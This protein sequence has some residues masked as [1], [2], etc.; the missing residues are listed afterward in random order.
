MTKS[1]IP[2]A[3][4]S[5][6][7]L[8]AAATVDEVYAALRDGAADGALAGGGALRVEAVAAGVRLVGLRTPTLPP[9]THTSCYWLG[10]DA[11]AG[12]FVAVDP[13]TPYADE[14]GRLFELIEREAASGRV[15]ERVIL[16]HHH[17]DHVGAADALR[18]RFGVPIAA[19]PATAALLAGVL[20]IDEPLADEQ[21]LALGAASWQVLATPGHAPGHVCLWRASDGA[22]VAGDMVAGIGTILIDPSDG[23]M[24]AYLGSL[25][26]LAALAPRA[27][28]PA[29][30]PLVPDGEARLRGYV[31]HR[32]AREAR[33]VAA[34][35]QRG[36]ASVAR[37]TEVAYADTPSALWP[38][39]ARSLSSH[40]GK[41][42]ADGR[43][44]GEGVDPVDG[45]PAFSLL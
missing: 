25:E 6:D 20:P 10:P 7:R 19:H 11:G 43:V 26:R 5:A 13:A 37:L 8:N 4:R 1:T 12:R 14:Q 34:L 33:V 38:L 15:L 42:I 28:L 27:L 22:L 35:H 32:L 41:L 45:Q 29:H 21:A 23:D 36:P 18:Q 16:T 31:A 40:L 2:P 30:G 3:T 9:A 44:A 17:G 39:A 24:G